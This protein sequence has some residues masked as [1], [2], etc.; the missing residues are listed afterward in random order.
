MVAN[1]NSIAVRR[2]I[3]VF[4]IPETTKG[5]LVVPAAGNYI[6]PVGMPELNQT[7]SYTESD[8]IQNSRDTLDRFQD[9][10]SAGTW[11]MSV[12][13]R[14][15]GTAGTAPM[16]KTLLLSHYGAETVSASTSVTYSQAIEKPSFSIWVRIDHTMRFCAG[17]T[18]SDLKISPSTKGALQFDFSGGFMTSGVVGTQDLSAAI[19]ALDTTFTP[20]DASCYSVGGLVEF[21]DVSADTVDDNSGAGYAITGVNTTT[22]VVTTSAI[23][24]AFDVDDMVRPFL[25][26]GTKVG[27]PIE[28]RKATTQIN[29]ISTNVRKFDI[30]V[31]DPCAY[32]DDEMT[33]SGAVEDYVPDRRKIDGTISLVMRKNDAKYFVDNLDDGALVPL[34]LVVG[35]AAGSIVTI[36]MPQSALDVPSTVDSA[37]TVGL[38]MPFT[39]LGNAGED[40]MTITFT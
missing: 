8:E 39:S 16:E 34:T 40:S 1:A 28:N 35:D 22:N 25:P 26:T 29:S 37:P 17:A 12:Y 38:D 7:P 11:S 21:Y 36:T 18:V 15:S 10:M 9:R 32:Q 24:S 13:C 5:A 33:T 3:D 6:I 27:T 20:D 31:N 4:V 14:P 19:V 2:N 30:S 23:A